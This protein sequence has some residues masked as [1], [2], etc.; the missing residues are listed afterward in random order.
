M[1]L[2]IM[3]KSILINL[4]IISSTFNQTIFTNNSFKSLTQDC[5]Q[6]VASINQN[7]K[8]IITAEQELQD[9]TKK[10]Q[11]HKK[12]CEETI[13]LNL[14]QMKQSLELLR[15]NV[16]YQKKHL[17]KLSYLGFF[18]ITLIA[19]IASYNAA[20]ADTMPVKGISFAIAALMTSAAPCYFM[21]YN[22]ASEEA[23]A[24]IQ[25]YK[26]LEQEIDTVLQK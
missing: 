1:G 6:L 8:N 20:I 21:L 11:N 13:R 22:T 7:R 17:K 4:L 25:V 23:E 10:D 16:I 2:Q 14:K 19:C 18:E 15:K 12:A 24:C 3:K 26:E 9:T 5:E